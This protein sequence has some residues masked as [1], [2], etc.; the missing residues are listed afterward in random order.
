MICARRSGFVS[1]RV[2]HISA[3]KDAHP[4]EAILVLGLGES[5]NLLSGLTMLSIG[6]N[7][8]GRRFTPTY[9]VNVNVRAGYKGD[10]FQFIENT[11]ARAIFTHMPA[12]QG[13]PKCPVVVFELA[14]TGIAIDGDSIPYFRDSP[15]VAVSIAAYMGATKIGL[16]GVDFTHNH[17]WQKDGPHRLEK[18]FPRIND[19]YGKLH[20]HLKT[21][22]VDLVNLSS[23]SKLTSIPKAALNTWP[24]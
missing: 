11:G 7:D 22:G 15:F 13:K 10:R 23:I 20:D 19:A 2:L 18:E 16:L 3:Y 24:N 4:N 12:E 17:F 9:L 6:V 1:L 14:K 5:V 21:R 8:L